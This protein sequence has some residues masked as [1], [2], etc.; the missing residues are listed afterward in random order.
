MYLSRIKLN[1][2]LRDT[3]KALTRPS[4]LH[5]GI[6]S[7]F[8]GERERRLW[9]LDALGGQPYILLLSTEKPDLEAFSEQFGFPGEYE[10]KSYEAL[11]KGITAGSR[12]RFRLTANPTVSKAKPGER[13]KV[14][15]HIS[16]QYQNEWLIAKAEVNGFSVSGDDFLITGTRWHRFYKGAQKAKPVCLL[17]VTYEGTL[18]VTDP[19]VFRNALC[20][21]I[22]REKAYGMGLLTVMRAK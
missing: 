1:P 8:P 22:G 19:D 11:L 6:E 3:M 12:W 5:G 20:N 2:D 7:A 4:M 17:A 14:V 10:T 13:G 16:Q 15:A 9:R 21:G 18:E